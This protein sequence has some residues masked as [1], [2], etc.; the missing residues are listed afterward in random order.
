MQ[1]ITYLRAEWRILIYL[2][3]INLSLSCPSLSYLCVMFW[4][5]GNKKFRTWSLFHKTRQQKLR[6]SLIPI[7][8]TSMESG[9]TTFCLEKTHRFVEFARTLLQGIMSFRFVRFV[10]A[11]YRPQNF[12]TFPVV[13]TY[14]ALNAISKTSSKWWGKVKCAKLSV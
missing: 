5:G 8:W 4:S 11:K 9:C 13:C 3:K 10:L 6:K 14:T 12:Y 2:F 7:L 1:L